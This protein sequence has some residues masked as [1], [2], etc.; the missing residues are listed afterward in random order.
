MNSVKEIYS[1][2]ALIGSRDDFDS[3]IDIMQTANPSIK[4]IDNYDRTLLVQFNSASDIH[5][6]ENTFSE[7]VKSW[8]GERLITCPIKYIYNLLPLNATQYILRI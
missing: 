5:E 1:N 2:K 4:V 6:F 3:L 8:V 7:S